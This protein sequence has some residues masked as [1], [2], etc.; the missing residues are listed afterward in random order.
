MSGKVSLDERRRLVPSR[1]R[2]AIRGTTR[3]TWRSERPAHG[4]P[5]R[6]LGR[7]DP[8]LR[9]QPRRATNAKFEDIKESIRTSG[10]RSRLP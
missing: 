1:C 3:A 5:D 4:V 9:E 2:W 6:T 8:S 7:R 10:L